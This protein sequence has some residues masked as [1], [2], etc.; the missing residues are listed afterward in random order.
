LD[1][2]ARREF[3]SFEQTNTITHRES[4]AWRENVADQLRR[5]VETFC[6]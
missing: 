6:F 2:G 1:A 4:Q 3:P 5:Q